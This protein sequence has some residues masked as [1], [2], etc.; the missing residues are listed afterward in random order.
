MPFYFFEDLGHIRQSAGMACCL[1][2]YRYIEKKQ[3]FKFLLC[4]LIGYYFHKTAVVFLPA[5]WIANAYISTR[6]CVIILI[7]SIIISPFKPYLLFGNLFE[8]ISIDVLSHATGGYFSY[9]SLEGAGFT[10]ADVVKIIII[11]II[12]FNDN[13]IINT[14]D[15]K[16]YMKMRNLVI[17]YFFLYYSLKENVIFSVRLPGYYSAFYIILIAMIIKYSAKNISKLIYFYVIIYIY[18]M[19]WRFWP[20]SVALG[21]DKFSNVFNTNI[22]I[23]NF[24]PYE[25]ADKEQN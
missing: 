16:N 3:L 12:L 13:Y 10:M 6:Q 1:F 21:F 24:I 15:D 5:Y 22:D 7:I 9:Q 25:F 18:L 4:V 17:C 19:S 14:T 8:N 11:F 20:N 2:S 23:N